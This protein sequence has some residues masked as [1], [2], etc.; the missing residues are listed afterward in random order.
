MACSLATN[1]GS[2]PDL[3][4]TCQK[5]LKIIPESKRVKSCAA[6]LDLSLITALDSCRKSTQIFESSKRKKDPVC[7]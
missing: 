1:V 7:K 2:C 4:C 5:G 3:K 6:S